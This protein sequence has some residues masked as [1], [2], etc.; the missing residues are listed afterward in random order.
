MKTGK[1]VSDLIKPLVLSGVYKDE[2]S[3]LKDI[4]A[5]YIERKKKICDEAILALEKKYRKDFK[6]FT[7]DIESKA[8]VELEEDWMEWKSAIEMKKAYGEALKE[9]IESGTKVQSSENTLVT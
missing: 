8:T 2:V 9:I 3:A 4:I 7:K 6:M 5:D 1:I